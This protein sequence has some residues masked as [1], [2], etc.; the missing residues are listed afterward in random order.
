MRWSTA[1]FMPSAL[2]ATTIGSPE[3]IARD[4]LGQRAADAERAL[5]HAAEFAGIAL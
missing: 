1:A 2:A 4:P 5:E 3:A